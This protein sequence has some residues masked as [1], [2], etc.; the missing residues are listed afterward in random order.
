MKN[1]IKIKNIIVKI[2]ADIFAPIGLVLG[3]YIILNGNL[4]PVGGFQGGVLIAFSVMLIYLGYGSEG[5]KKTFN[6]ELIR[7]N[8]GI[9][10]IAY[11][12]FALIGIIC[13]ANFC[14]NVFFNIGNIQKLYNL[15][16]TFWTSSAVIY[17]VLTGVGF[18]MLLMLVLLPSDG[19]SNNY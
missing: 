11:S 17:K 6:M 18:L 1:D 19:N 4:A 2:G 3:F 13:V 14:K 7:K 12:F 10:V 16:T 8:E 5:L 9:E 15:E